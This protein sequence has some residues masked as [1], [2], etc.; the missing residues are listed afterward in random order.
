MAEILLTDVLGKNG[1]DWAVGLNLQVMNKRRQAY[2]QAL[3]SADIGDF[4]ALKD[5]I[6]DRRDAAGSLT[7]SFELLH[8]FGKKHDI[9]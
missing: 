6:G 9:F 2:I 3:R 1:F 4:G 8:Q 7:S 5:C